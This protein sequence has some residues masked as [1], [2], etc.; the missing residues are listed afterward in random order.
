MKL[1]IGIATFRRDDGLSEFFLSRA[2]N[3]VRYQTHQD[4]KVFL[5]G[6]K[7]DN[8][9]EFHRLADLIPADK[10]YQEN[11]PVAVE[12]EKY[13]WEMKQLSCSGGV[14]AYNRAIEVALSHGYDY[15][16]HLDHDDYWAPDHLEA[17]NWAIE[18]MG[19]P[20]VVHTCAKFA[21]HIWPDGVTQILPNIPLTG[22]IYE[23]RPQPCNVVH[24]TICM[25]HRQIPLR[26]RDVYAETGQIVEADID[27]WLRLDRF[28][29]QSSLKSYVIALKTCYKLKSP[30]LYKYNIGNVV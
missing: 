3:C 5:I 10:I 6:D 30:W 18:S 29:T 11:L 19:Y 25:N 21:N 15:L 28:L 23:G 1:G 26:Y 2:L 7:Y 4:Y 12:R 13:T 8:D 20:S 22:L 14:N 17:I 27:M 9:A 24:S 16:C